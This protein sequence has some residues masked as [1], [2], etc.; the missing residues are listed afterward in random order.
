[1]NKNVAWHINELHQDGWDFCDAVVKATPRG[2]SLAQAA[3]HYEE[4]CDAEC[5]DG[6]SVFHFMK[7]DSS[8]G[9]KRM[10]A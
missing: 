4:Q 9:R 2:E 10:S 5:P 3:T 6:Y 8:E 7:M 1:M